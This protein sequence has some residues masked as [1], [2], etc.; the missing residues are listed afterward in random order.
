MRW[1][2]DL[3]YLAAAILFLP[4]LAYD[5]LV[6]KK[7][8]QGWRERFGSV[9]RS[10]PSRPAIW[11][12]AVSLGE[13]N[14]VRTLVTSL[15][16][17]LPRF[18]VVVSSTT[19]T[20]TARAAELFGKEN[21]FRFPLD[22]SVVIS[23]VL[24]RIQP[25]MIILLELEVWY[26]LVRM[27]HARAVPVAVVNGRITARS[28]RRL[29]YIKPFA[30]SMFRRL[31]WVGAQ[32]E[33]IA[34]RFRRL[35]VPQERVEVTS[36]LKWDTAEVA[37][38]VSGQ[39]ELSAAMGLDGSRF[40]WVCGS[41]G[42]E[43]ESLILEA[44]QR[45]RERWS[46]RVS[47]LTGHSRRD[48]H[49][50]P[51]VLFLVPRKPERFDS[52]A[53]EIQRTGFECVRRSQRRDRVSGAPL[54]E[55]AVLLGDTTGELR[56]GYALADVV[57]IGRSLVPQG[58]S[59]PIEAAALGKPLIVGPHMENFESAVEAFRGVDALR[60]VASAAELADTVADFCCNLE[61]ARAMGQR[62]QRTVVDRKGATRRTMA[63]IVEILER[64]E[65][66]SAE[67]PNRTDSGL[68]KEQPC[69]T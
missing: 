8:R 37:D 3:F 49:N 60:V 24:N 41:T 21:V 10:D 48:Q 57:F 25:R 64:A 22:F 46:E 2:A 43:E 67:F 5:L 28:E 17:C 63:R 38:R 56:M 44:Y 34:D 9:R 20:G 13:V 7:N 66:A 40:L 47:G 16:E 59:D 61:S 52:V 12:H 6:L 11:I 53:A 35:G 54:R 68:R 30:R 4:F 14:A 19:D 62:G 1:M 26:N 27:A 18:S 69:R 31:S 39:S 23:R 50:H 65:W 32:D 33:T 15:R 36:S 58:G 42:A 51:P 29:S 55:S 45:L